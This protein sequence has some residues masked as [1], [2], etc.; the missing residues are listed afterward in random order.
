MKLNS[1]NIKKNDSLHKA[2][3]FKLI[4]KPSLRFY[5]PAFFADALALIKKIFIQSYI[6]KINIPKN[7]YL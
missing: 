2:R 5:K 4:P 1:K 3:V 7:N 6:Y